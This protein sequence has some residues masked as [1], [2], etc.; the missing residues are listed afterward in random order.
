MPIH[1]NQVCR[2]GNLSGGDG[3][4]KKEDRDP[5]EKKIGTE[6]A[7][8]HNNSHMVPEAMKCGYNTT[9]LGD[10]CTC[11]STSQDILFGLIIWG[12]EKS[13]TQAKRAQINADVPNVLIRSRT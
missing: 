8:G 2:H 1:L 3:K 7:L 12:E 6:I 9:Y 5:G 4:I 13:F 10:D 11:L